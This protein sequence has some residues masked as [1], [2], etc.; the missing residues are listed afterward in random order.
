[1]QWVLV[2]WVSHSIMCSSRQS[3]ILNFTFRE[4]K[5]ILIVLDACRYRQFAQSL[6]AWLMHDHNAACKAELASHVGFLTLAPDGCL[7]SAV[8]L[9]K[10]PDLMY[11]I[12]KDETTEP[13]SHKPQRK[14]QTGGRKASRNIG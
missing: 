12:I 4:R 11:L 2:P 13:A 10:N 3:S 14:S 7:T 1:M 9:W 6:W 8:A 5:C